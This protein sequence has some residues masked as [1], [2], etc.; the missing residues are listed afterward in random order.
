MP[1]LM[2]QSTATDAVKERVYWLIL[3]SG[4]LLADGQAEEGEI[5]AVPEL[6]NAYSNHCLQ[7]GV[8]KGYATTLTLTERGWHSGP[9]ATHFQSYRLQQ[10]PLKGEL[11]PLA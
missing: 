10:Y 9:F 6:L 8:C 2:E 11:E 7:S 5:F 3:I 1:L 4:F